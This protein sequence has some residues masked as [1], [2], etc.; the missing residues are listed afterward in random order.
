MGKGKT[1][2]LLSIIEVRAPVAEK[3][4]EA[5]RL[6]VL[7]PRG[8]PWILFLRSN[9]FRQIS[10]LFES[11]VRTKLDDKPRYCGDNPTTFIRDL[12]D[13]TTA[14]VAVPAGFAK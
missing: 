14:T 1:K 9:R 3:L 10:Q 6:I 4:F 13:G 8:N 12:A 2:L 7:V 11:S 5:R